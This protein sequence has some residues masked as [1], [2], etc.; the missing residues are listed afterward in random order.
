[1]LGMQ[2]QMYY[3]S[4]DSSHVY[5]GPGDDKF[6]MGDEF[7]GTLASVLKHGVKPAPAGEHNVP[8]P[9]R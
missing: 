3:K 8:S 7:T 5:Y 2:P 1:M 4:G 6:P 9:P